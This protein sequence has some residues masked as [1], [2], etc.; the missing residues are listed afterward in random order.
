[1]SNFIQLEQVSKWFESPAGRFEALRKVD[2]HIDEGEY[3]AIV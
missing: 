3:V 1:M 2:L